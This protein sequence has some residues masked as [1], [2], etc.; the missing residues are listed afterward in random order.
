M[1][2]IGLAMS[3][4]MEI[5]LVNSSSLRMKQQIRGQKYRKKVIIT[6][7]ES[8]YLITKMTNSLVG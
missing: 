1:I 6:S 7:A 4:V 8:P 5:S 3:Q 2:G